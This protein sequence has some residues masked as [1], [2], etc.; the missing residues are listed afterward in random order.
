MAIPGTPFRS[1]Q[2]TIRLHE[3]HEAGCVYT[4]KARNPFGPLPERHANN[5]KIQRGCQEALSH[6]HTASII[7]GVRNQPKEKRPFSNTAAGVFGIHPEL[8]Q[9][10]HLATISQVA[11]LE[12]SEASG[13]PIDAHSQAKEKSPT[14]SSHSEADSKSQ[15]PISSDELAGIDLTSC[16][17]VNFEIKDGCP[18]LNY[19]DTENVAGRTPVV[20]RRKKRKISKLPEYVLRRFP[21]EHPFHAGQTQ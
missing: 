11:H 4:K 2:C 14:V 19:Q 3:A 12:T 6:C 16:S 7:P 17:N 13:T 15:S 10:D 1:K 21:P 5:G 20:G 9:D 18:G 8:Q